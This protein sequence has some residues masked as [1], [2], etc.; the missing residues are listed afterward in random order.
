MRQ[1]AV[2][3]TT[4]SGSTAADFKHYAASTASRLL[5]LPPPLLAAAIALL[6]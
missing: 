5:P 1:L 6:G 4:A 2:T 3:I